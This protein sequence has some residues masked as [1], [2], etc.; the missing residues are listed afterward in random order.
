[1]DGFVEQPFILVVN[2]EDAILKL[3]V[4][5]LLTPEVIEYIDADGFIDIEN[6]GYFI[7][8]EDYN[9][10]T[11][12]IISVKIVENIL[13]KLKKFVDNDW[14][15]MI[16]NDPRTRC[17]ECNKVLY[18]CKYHF[19]ITKHKEILCKY[20]ANL[21]LEN[22]CKHKR[23]NNRLTRSSKTGKVHEICK[24][25]FNFKKVE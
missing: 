17:R 25:C 1:M 5:N 12:E 4:I 14:E 8:F 15:L 10:I 23:C 3:P 24:A 18:Q 21:P 16:A 19:D 22:T 7:T 20:C 13:P 9:Q 6:L 11:S 2:T